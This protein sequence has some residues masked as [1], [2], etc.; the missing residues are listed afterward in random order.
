MTLDPLACAL[1]GHMVGD[2]LLQNDWMAQNKKQRSFPCVV[3]CALWASAVSLF[4]GW[5]PLPWLFLFLLH[6][7]QDRT[8]SFSPK[9]V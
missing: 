8:P 9:L 4:A 3:H 1:V 5:G 7:A 6:F 2:Y